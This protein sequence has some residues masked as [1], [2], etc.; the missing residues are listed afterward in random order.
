MLISIFWTYDYKLKEVNCLFYLFWIVFV[1]APCIKHLYLFFLYLL[2]IYLF[3]LSIFHSFVLNIVLPFLPDNFHKNLEWNS[4][5]ITKMKKRHF[6]PPKN[7]ILK[8]YIFT[9]YCRYSSVF[10]FGEN[11]LHHFYSILL[12]FINECYFCINFSKTER[13]TQQERE[14]A[15]CVIKK[16]IERKKTCDIV[17]LINCPLCSE[18]SK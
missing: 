15:V 16:E 14:R 5:V 12:G 11:L 10:W 18:I 13:D 2:F 9:R 4:F 8:R 1:L 6:T 7:T 17:E 3:T